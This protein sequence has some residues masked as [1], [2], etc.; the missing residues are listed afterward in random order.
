MVQPD[1]VAAA[2]RLALPEALVEVE[3]L[4]GGGDHLQVKVLWEGFRDLSRVK[5]HQLVYGAL[6]AELASEAIHALALT[7]SCPS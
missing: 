1:A 5:Q 6:R 7:T 3:D 2:I 4:T